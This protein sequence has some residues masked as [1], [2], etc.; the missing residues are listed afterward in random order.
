MHPHYEEAADHESADGPEE[1]KTAIR[2]VNG[3]EEEESE[4]EGLGNATS[5]QHQRQ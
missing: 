3:D 2:N 5:P 1:G 4:I